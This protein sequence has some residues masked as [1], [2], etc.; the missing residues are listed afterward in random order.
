[1]ARRNDN[2]AQKKVFTA[3]SIWTRP[4]FPPLVRWS[5]TFGRGVNAVDPEQSLEHEQQ[6]RHRSNHQENKVIC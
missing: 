1:M 2:L 3:L 6:R 4:P 5:S